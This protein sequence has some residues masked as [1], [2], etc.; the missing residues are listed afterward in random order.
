MSDADLIAEKT[1][2]AVNVLAEQDV[3]CWL[4]FCRETGDIPEPCLPFLLHFDVVWPTAIL[5]SK[6]GRKAVVLGRH[7]APNARELDTY[8]VYPYDESLAEPLSDLL[9]EIDPDEIAVNY[10]RDDNTADG[11]THG[12]YLRLCE[13]LDGT[14]YADSLTSAEDVIS[15]VRG[16]KS[17]TERERVEQAVE[18]TGE[19]L[20][21]MADRW[22]P[23]WA[24]SNA[25]DWLHDRMN[26]RD[27]GSA[28]SWDYCPTVHAG[29]ESEMGH[30]LP[31]DLTL[32]PGEVL[33]VDFGV[34]QD[35]Y[36]ADMQRLFYRP[37]AEH[38]EPPAELQSAFEDVRAAIEAAR[39]ETVP[40]VQGYEVDDAA[41]E[42]LTDRGW[43]EYSHATGHQVGRNAHDGGTLLGPRWDRY[44]TSPEGEIRAGEI[45][46]V[47]L[48]V[49]TEWGYLGQEEMV[50]VTEVGTEW[51]TDP[52]EELRVLA[53]GS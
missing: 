9:G 38:P 43:P 39:E 19:L 28:W 46:T 31:G 7:D 49:E 11:L 42:E 21:V 29:D 34:K 14:A 26:E 27:L 17:P 40:G 32:P 1:E 50:L 23:D 16:V 10:S 24:E 12:M 44:G 52:Q 41:R 6:E 45:Y 33:H 13:L 8:E 20:A 53:D 36:S 47:E 35:G 30:T 5:I 25:S 51:L 4:T 37:S 3:D 22:E 48:G 15:T 2:Q 18:T